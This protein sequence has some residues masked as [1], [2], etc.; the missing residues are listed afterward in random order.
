MRIR[1]QDTPWESWWRIAGTPND[2]IEPSPDGGKVGLFKHYER[3]DGYDLAVI[4]IFPDGQIVRVSPFMLFPA[5]PP[6]DVPV[7]AQ[8]SLF[9]GAHIAQ[10]EK[11]N[12]PEREEAHR[13]R[14]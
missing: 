12:E 1:Q 5:E 6:N 9:F 8:L 3:I 11:T 4:Q 2:S 10:R 14:G 13:H 7:G